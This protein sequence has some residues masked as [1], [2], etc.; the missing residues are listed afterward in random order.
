MTIVTDNKKMVYVACAP[1]EDKVF[2]KFLPVFL[3]KRFI[4]KSILDVT[5]KVLK[6]A[7]AQCCYNK[8]ERQTTY[9][10]NVVKNNTN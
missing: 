4:R 5:F 3:L 2:V 6:Y 9:A 10:E 8:S 7:K 1:S